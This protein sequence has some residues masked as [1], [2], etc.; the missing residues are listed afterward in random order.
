MK[1]AFYEDPL[2]LGAIFL[3]FIYLSGSQR[4]LFSLSLLLLC[5]LGSTAAKIFDSLESSSFL[6]FKG[7]ILLS[8]PSRI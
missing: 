3:R 5:S 4:S 8:L 1:A 6:S 7:E 2:G